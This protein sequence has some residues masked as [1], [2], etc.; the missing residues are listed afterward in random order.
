MNSKFASH[1]LHIGA[2]TEQVQFSTP[3]AVRMSRIGWIEGN[4][5][6]ATLYF[7]WTMRTSGASILFFC[8]QYSPVL[9][10]GTL[11][12]AVSIDSDAETFETTL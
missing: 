11:L 1:S 10:A 2:H 9:P 4:K 8:A 12:Y 5:E 3:L 7:D 6:M